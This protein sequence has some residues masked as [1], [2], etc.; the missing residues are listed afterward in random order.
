MQKYHKCSRKIANA[1]IPSDN[2]AITAIAVA[3]RFSPR[4]SGP[5]TSQTTEKPE[6]ISAHPSAVNR[7]SKRRTTFAGIEAAVKPSEFHAVGGRPASAT[8]TSPRPPSI[9]R[10][11][12][13]FRSE[14]AIFRRLCTRT[15]H[16]APLEYVNFP[17]PN[18]NSGV[19]QR[20]PEGLRP[21]MP[22]PQKGSGAPATMRM[23]GRQ[24]S[25]T[26]LLDEL[27]PWFTLAAGMRKNAGG[28]FGWIWL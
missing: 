27:S 11:P 7:A 1:F 22:T 2:T 9:I 16:S 5:L 17:K 6:A 10:L 4:R 26:S 20:R 12:P 18:K 3:A 25:L 28:H 19:S 23:L 14:R 15:E 21:E 24:T 8:K 13:Q